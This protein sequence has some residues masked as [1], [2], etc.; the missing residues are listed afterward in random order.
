LLA[1]LPV[2]GLGLGGLLG[3]GPVTVLL[4]T[5]VGVACL[6]LGVLLD[7]L[8]LWWTARIARSVER[9]P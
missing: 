8:G 4:T 6:V 2:A 1:L 5:P 9:P 7:L 3:A